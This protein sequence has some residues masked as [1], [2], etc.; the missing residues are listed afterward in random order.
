MKNVL[1]DRLQEIVGPDGIIHQPAEVEAETRTCIPYR[2]IPQCIVYPG[3]AEHVQRIVTVARE[4][5]VPIW[6]VS[7]GKNWGYGEK[8]ACY[9]GGITMVLVRMK[10]I[11]IVDEELRR[12]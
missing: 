8:S 6:P 4:F 9:R 5:H 3:S 2:E 10:K 1:A 11:D 12:E 7:T